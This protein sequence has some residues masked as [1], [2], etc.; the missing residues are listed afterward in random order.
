[1]KLSKRIV[2]IE[3]IRKEMG[4]SKDELDMVEQT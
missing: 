4:I 3:L 2:E 1:M